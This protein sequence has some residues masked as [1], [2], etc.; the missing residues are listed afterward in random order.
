MSR[1]HASH[2]P[3]AHTHL[4]SKNIMVN[5]SDLTIQIADYNL[6]SLKKFAKL[7]AHYNNFT[8]W[9][10]SE[11][12]LCSDKK[13]CFYDQPSVDVYS[14]GMILYELE[15]GAVPFGQMDIRAVKKKLREQMRPMIP[16]QS[17]KRLAN[18]IRRCWQED[19]ESRPSFEQIEDLL[20]R[21]RFTN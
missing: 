8:A 9:T 16:D 5:P 14:F 4:S 18:L 2:S 15:T 3:P 10:A 11:V 20:Q 17:D 13:L 7:F 19:F 21:C 1:L 12:L 6:K